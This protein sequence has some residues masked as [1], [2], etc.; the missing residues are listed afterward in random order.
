MAEEEW[1]AHL[2][3]RTCGRED[4]QED[5]V[6]FPYEPTP[7]SVLERLSESGL[8]ERG[9]QLLDYGCGKGRVPAYFAC[10][11]DCRCLGIEYDRKLYEAAVEN[12]ASLPTGKVSFCHADAETFVVPNDINRCFFFNPFGE[13]V[14]RRVLGRLTDSYYEIPREILLF[15]YY[16]QDDQV[17]LLMTMDEIMFV[18]EI[19]CMDL[20]PGN[21][22]RERILVFA[23]TG[24]EAMCYEH[25]RELREVPLR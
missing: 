18:D 19:S 17:A 12:M 24:L 7:Y 15:F 9:D 8:I 3:I 22:P 11:L 25:S 5:T 10:K 14:L 4:Y 6:H 23:L 2:G 1:D 21:N 13:K 20:F 16:P